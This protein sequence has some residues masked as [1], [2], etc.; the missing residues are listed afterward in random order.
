M[1]S[2]ILIIFFTIFVVISCLEIYKYFFNFKKSLSRYLNTNS[3]KELQYKTESNNND[4]Q[5]L[6][7]NYLSRIKSLTHQENVKLRKITNEINEMNIFNNKYW[8]IVKTLGNIEFGYPFTIGDTIILSESYIQNV[9]SDKL[10][11][12]LIHEKIHVNQRK[13]Q[14]YYF[15]NGLMIIMENL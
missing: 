4:K 8:K 7:K 15:L 11:N 2:I 9:G 5:K 6:I 1:T 13:N 12:T 10:M 14:D 3:I